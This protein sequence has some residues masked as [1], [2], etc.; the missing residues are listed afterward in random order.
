[1]NPFAD[2]ITY[3]IVD[4]LVY[5]LS[6]VALRH[7]QK[8]FPL[9][10]ILIYSD[11]P[12][13]W[14]EFSDKVVPITKI[15]SMHDYTK[16]LFLELPKH[17]VTDFALVIQWDGFVL[18]P[19]RFSNIFLE[20]DYI[21]ATWGWFNHF[22]VGNGGFSLRSKRLINASKEIYISVE[23]D[24]AEDLFLCRKM[25]VFLEDKFGIS[26]APEPIANHFSTEYETVKFDTFGFHGVHWLPHVYKKNIAYFIENIPIKSAV[27]YEKYIF[28]ALRAVSPESID[29]LRQRLISAKG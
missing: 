20:Y 16:T 4:T 12:V 24:E 7:S 23:G 13:K 17:L 26:F 1:M 22:K 10:N 25:R 21:G 6:L 2:R 14:E 27:K 8:V 15:A 5:E 9:N 28:D 11:D 18:N 3:V 29:P 19:D